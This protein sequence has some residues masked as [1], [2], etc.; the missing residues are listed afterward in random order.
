MVSREA[1]FGTQQLRMG[2]LDFLALCNII[3]Y[4]IEISSIRQYYSE[5]AVIITLHAAEKLRERGI[6]AKEIRTAVSNGEIIEQYPGDF[7]YASCLI[8]GYTSSK[9][10]LHIVMSDEGTASRII[11]AYYPDEKRWSADYKTRKEE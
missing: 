4:M 8:L 7:P 11:T 10:P 9:K 3:L 6:K 2:R 5:D 1:A